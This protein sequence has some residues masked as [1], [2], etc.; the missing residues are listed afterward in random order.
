MNFL[1][2]TKQSDINLFFGDDEH[3]IM[4]EDH[5]TMAHIMKEA[6]IFPSVSQARKNGWNKPIP[7]G[8]NEFIVGKKR[9]KIWIFVEKVLD[10]G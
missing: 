1:K 3:V 8:F 4:I 6:G 10:K 2:S 9:K 7:N 5:W